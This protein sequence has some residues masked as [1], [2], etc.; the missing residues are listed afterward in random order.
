MLMAGSIC[1]LIST[2]HSPSRSS[3]RHPLHRPALYDAATLTVL[4]GGRSL[5]PR[6][7]ALLTSPPQ[8]DARHVEGIESFEVNAMNGRRLL[9]ASFTIIAFDP[10]DVPRV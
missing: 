8:R 3:C 5:S 10:F 9:I 7:S 6:R 1:L 2:H 4:R